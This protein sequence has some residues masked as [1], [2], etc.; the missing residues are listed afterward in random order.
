MVCYVRRR[1]R[2]RAYLGDKSVINVTDSLFWLL[3]GRTQSSHALAAP[4]RE[5][6][7]PHFSLPKPRSPRFT[8]DDG[9][10]YVIR[11][12]STASL[13]S[14]IL[15]PI[16]LHKKLKKMPQSR[17][18]GIKRC[19]KWGR[20]RLHSIV[21][22]SSTSR[23]FFAFAFWL[24]Y[25]RHRTLRRLEADQTFCVQCLHVWCHLA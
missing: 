17:R 18:K 24:F 16:T 2:G 6:S 14:P 9:N 12:H 15:T 13:P 11:R 4:Q 3:Q 21:F 19:G 20:S 25:A 8:Q 7:T 23:H 22:L 1:E 10:L 5:S